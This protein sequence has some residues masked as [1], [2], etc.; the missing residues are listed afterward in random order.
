M[1]FRSRKQRYSTPKTDTLASRA[2]TQRPVA[3]YSIFFV[4]SV[5]LVCFSAFLLFL[6]LFSVFVFS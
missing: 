2:H 3:A 5:L 4:L 6:F 1:I